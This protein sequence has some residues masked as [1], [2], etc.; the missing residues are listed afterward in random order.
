MKQPPA[1]NENVKKS[2]QGNTKKDTSIEVIFRKALWHRNVRFRKNCK[3][4]L[5]TP[6]I[7][8]KK[9]RLI[10]FLDGDFW[11][12]RYY[13]GVRNHKKFWD[14][15]IKRNRERDLEYTIRLRDEGWIVLRFWEREIRNDLDRC[16][17][18]VVE[19]I[20]KAKRKR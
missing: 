17:D 20:N 9:Y 19:T 2:M 16:V 6:D 1:T 18:T 4:I 7:A 15:K 3:H 13:H 8:I 10:V 14:E 11:H 12:G 5:G